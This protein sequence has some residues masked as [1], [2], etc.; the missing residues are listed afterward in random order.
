MY[1]AKKK[2]NM[3]IGSENGFQIIKD[4]SWNSFSWPKK[5]SNIDFNDKSPDISD[6]PVSNNCKIVCVGRNYVD[7]AKEL[8]NI[9]P[10]EP[11]LFWK[12]SSSLLAPQ[13][14]IILPFQSK[15]VQYETELVAVIGKKGKDIQTMNAMDHILGYTIGLDITARDLQ[16][17]DKTWFRGKGFDTF[18]PVGPIIVPKDEISLDDCELSLDINGELKQ[19]GNI[20]NFIFKLPYLIH[21]ISQIITLNCGDIIF[22]GTPEGVG[23]I[24]TGDR[25][26]AKI[27]G[28][29]ELQVSVK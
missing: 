23:N 22:T 1:L 15:K 18:A 16:K 19:K 21:Y 27:E 4:F 10:E 28:I 26:S 6:F 7:H 8:G 20:K 17:K 24:V 2:N 25:L 11:L 13:G 5:G 9:V 29:G 12:P 3:I 14:I